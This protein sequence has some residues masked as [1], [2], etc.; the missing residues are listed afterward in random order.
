MGSDAWKD[1]PVIALGGAFG[2]GVAFALTVAIP[3]YN[4]SSKNEYDFK[5]QENEGKLKAVEEKYASDKADIV[6]MKTLRKENAFWRQQLTEARVEVWQLSSKK[7]FR[8]GSPAP[9]GLES[10]VNG[11]TIDDVKSL[12]PKSK[13]TFSKP[14]LFVSLKGGFFETMQIRTSKG[15]VVDVTY[16]VADNQAAK[17]NLFGAVTAN[18]GPSK[19]KVLNDEGE[20]LFYWDAG[21]REVVVYGHQYS[22]NEKRV[23]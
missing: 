2:A 6:N 17:Q 22:I 7:P 21:T 8:P 19:K 23:L 20:P 1:H 4:T 3:I 9:V 15:R 18:F 13:I 5:L 12:F 14:F 10:V 11:I 16:Y